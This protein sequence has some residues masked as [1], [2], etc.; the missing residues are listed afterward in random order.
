VRV[1]EQ[2]NS[3]LVGFPMAD[4]DDIVPA[5]EGKGVQIN[6]RCPQKLLDQIDAIRNRKGKETDR[7]S[8]ILFFIRRGIENHLEAS[9]QRELGSLPVGSELPTIADLRKHPAKK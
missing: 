7:T 9:R 4:L 2:D 5:G 3:N 8:V 6:F 1:G